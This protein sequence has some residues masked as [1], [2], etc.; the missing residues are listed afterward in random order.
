MLFGQVFGVEIDQAVHARIADKLSG[1]F[2]VRR[3]NLLPSNFFELKPE[4]MPAVDVVVGNPP[5]IRY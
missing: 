3:R 2:W 4:A 1:E 5:F